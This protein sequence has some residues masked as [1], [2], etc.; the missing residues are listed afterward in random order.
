MDI[1]ERNSW[2]SGSSTSSTLTIWTRTQEAVSTQASR[3]GVIYFENRYRC[4]DG[5]YRWLE[6]SSAPA[7][8]LIYAAARDITD[9]KR[10]EEALQESK[11]EAQ[12]VAREAL[13]MAEVGRIISSTLTVEEV[14]EPFAAVVKRI[15]PFDRIVINT[16]DGEKG[17]F[18]NVYMAGVEVGDR[19]AG[20]V[21]TLEGSGM[22]EMLRTKSPF[23]LQTEDFTDYQ[24]R[25]PMLLST[26]QA[27][28]RSILNVP[29][30]SPGKDHRGAPLE[31]F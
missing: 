9:R 11:E 31:V 23:L 15:I 8:N 7:G 3:Q 28:F 1:P 4:K 6:W 24:D 19:E 29:L 30:V 5:T 22:G 13:A 17:T 27:G 18:K 12:R 21:H 26:F 14:Y 25:F 2:R 16:I 20:K 10:V